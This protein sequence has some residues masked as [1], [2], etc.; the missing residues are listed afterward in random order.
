MEGKVWS[1]RRGCGHKGEDVVIKGK[2][3]SWRR[4]CGHEGGRCTH[5]GGVVMEK[6]WSWRERMEEG[7]LWSSGSH[8][9]KFVKM[10]KQELQLH[11][12]L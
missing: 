12:N 5:G 11:I 6:V 2:V 1:R 8:Y 10:K 3:W 9:I 4:G 7:G